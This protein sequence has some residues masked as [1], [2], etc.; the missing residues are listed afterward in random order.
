MAA[1]CP[2]PSQCCQ[3]QT[4]RLQSGQYYLLVSTFLE[5]FIADISWVLNLIWNFEL[6]M[7]VLLFILMLHQGHF[8]LFWSY[9]I[10]LKGFIKDS[11]LL[12]L[13]LTWNVRRQWISLILRWNDSNIIFIWLFL[14]Q[15]WNTLNSIWQAML[16]A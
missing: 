14:F 16:W 3:S 13:Q 6:N 8:E 15:E 11:P 9:F 5:I 1:F 4:C 2:G 10:L 12:H 7:Y